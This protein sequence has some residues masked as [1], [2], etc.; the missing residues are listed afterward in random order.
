M[1]PNTAKELSE[2]ETGTADDVEALLARVALQDRQA[3]DEL[4]ARTAS[5]LYP[6]AVSM[7]GE[8]SEAEDA[9]QESFIKIW[10]QASR[11]R[12]GRG[13]AMGWLAVLVR[14]TAIDCRRRRRDVPV[15]QT[16]FERTSELPGPE[17]LLA[18]SDEARHLHSCLSE[19]SDAERVPIRQ[20]FFAGLTYQALAERSGV[21]LGT[22]K[23]RIRRALMKLK[24]CF[25]RR[26]SEATATGEEWS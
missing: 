3:F 23:S 22:M 13:S 20:G 5:K 12:A 10:K 21:P 26:T 9:L 16:F 19:L 15:D 24:V 1:L 6:I 17:A 2:L 11:Y 8:G 14:N 7:L 4:Y 25:E 18:A